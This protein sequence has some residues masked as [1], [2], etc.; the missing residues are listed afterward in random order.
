[1]ANG[2][3]DD[4]VNYK[5]QMIMLP[6]RLPFY[7]RVHNEA[8][9]GE[10]PEAMPF[11]IYFDDVLK[12]YRQR[13]GTELNKMLKEVYESGSLVE[14]SLSNES[15]KI[16][17]DKL[18]GYIEGT[19]SVANRKILEIGCGSGPL[20]KE[21][22]KKNAIVL[23]VEPG[24]HVPS[25]NMGDIRI[26]RDFFP[27]KH[28]NDRFDIIVHYGVMEH[29]EDPVNFLMQQKQHLLKDGRIVISVPNCE[30]FLETGDISI[31]IHEHFNYFTRE[32]V[33]NVITAAGLYLQDISLFEG[34]IIATASEN[35]DHEI[36]GTES[37]SFTKE[38]FESLIISLN[39]K[40]KELFAK[41]D[42]KDVAVY[43]PFRGMN[44]LYLAGKL[45]CRLIDDNPEVKG[46]YMPCFTR[47]VENFEN[48]K[49]NPPRCILIYS[50]TFG[51]RIKEKCSKEKSLRTT[52]ILM[53]NELD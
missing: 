11:N 51:E 49:M 5:N 42:E 30:P 34:I 22:K 47:P 4:G 50:R 8:G 32:S 3:N 52:E 13:T 24:A 15:G 46:K 1:M 41:Y 23:G 14:G 17:L 26:I 7:F 43:V 20:L 27:S 39:Q 44:A 25:E 48:I 29:I 18:V 2:R 12:M 10:Y 35:G 37:G 38:K 45:N 28:I 6:A 16:Y 9:N 19:G 40:V 53:L 21:L 31:F 36:N 33:K